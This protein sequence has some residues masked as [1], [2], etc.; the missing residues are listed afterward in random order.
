MVGDKSTVQIKTGVFEHDCSRDHNNRHVN[1]NWIA[2][3]Y[4]E[5]FRVN[6]NWAISGIVQAV[7]T[8]QKVNISRLKA[9]RAKCIAHRCVCLYS[10]LLLLSL[11][12]YSI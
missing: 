1:A 2:M 10:F 4:F 6:L 9:Y 12:M 5:Q 8:N 7:K 11:H 3:N